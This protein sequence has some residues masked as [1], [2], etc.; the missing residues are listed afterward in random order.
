MSSK[1]RTPPKG[2]NPVK[3]VP[4][5][6]PRKPTPP[7]MGSQPA[8]GKHVPS[9][10]PGHQVYDCS[11]AVGSNVVSSGGKKASAQVLSAPPMSAE[12]PTPGIDQSAMG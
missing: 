5:S 6:T 8:N 3:P 2:A 9:N 10:V 11:G 12:Y 7:T 1:P 4:A